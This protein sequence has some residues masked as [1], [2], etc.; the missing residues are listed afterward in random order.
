M[1]ERTV[2]EDQWFYL[3]WAYL[4]VTSLWAPKAC[5][6][7]CKHVVSWPLSTPAWS[8]PAV[9]TKCHKLGG[10]KQHKCTIP[11]FWR[12]KSKSKMSAGSWSPWNL[13]QNS[14]LPLP[15]FWCLLD[16]LGISW[17][18]NTSLHSLPLLS[19]VFS[20]C[21]YVSSVSSPHYKDTSH[22]NLGST[23]PIGPHLS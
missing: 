6:I 23:S 7:T 4:S 20:V 1:F 18:A 5:I 22:V 17:L 16:I 11:Q 9:F 10:L 19:L 3:D 8:P 14:S 12:L 13:E 15:S 2:N 21:V